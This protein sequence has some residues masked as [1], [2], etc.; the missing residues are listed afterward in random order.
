MVDRDSLQRQLAGGDGDTWENKA[1]ELFRAKTSN[2][3]FEK[4][5]QQ[6]FQVGPKKNQKKYRV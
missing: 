2:E 1:D 5:K 3:I 4:R 6:Q